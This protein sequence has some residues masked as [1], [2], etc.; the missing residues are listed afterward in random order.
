MLYERGERVILSELIQDVSLHPYLF[1]LAQLPA[2]ALWG[3]SEAGSR[4]ERLQETRREINLQFRYVSLDLPDSDTTSGLPGVLQCSAS[5]SWWKVC[6][7]SQAKMAGFP[8]EHRWRLTL[9]WPNK[10]HKNL[11]L[12]VFRG[13]WDSLMFFM[14]TCG[15]VP[16]ETCRFPNFPTTFARRQ[17]L[18]SSSGAELRLWR[19]EEVG[20]PTVR[21][22]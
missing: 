1:S 12:S 8:T 22:C 10:N 7:V 20:Q 5:S 17:V 21:I 3:A 13:T 15:G 19:E 14:V 11:Y 4:S 2:A 16:I 6:D 18:C 9:L